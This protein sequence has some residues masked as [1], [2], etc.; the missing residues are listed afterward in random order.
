MLFIVEND[1]A[2]HIRKRTGS[3]VVGMKLEPSMGG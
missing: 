3:V 2:A 1:A